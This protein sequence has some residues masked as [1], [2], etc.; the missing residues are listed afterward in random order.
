MANRISP[1]VLGPAG[2]FAIQRELGRGQFG[3]VYL[4]H[5]RDRNRTVALK[6]LERRIVKGLG[7]ERIRQEFELSSS[8]HHDNLAR[9]YELLHDDGDALITMEA[10]E[11][12][13]FVEHVRRERSKEESSRAV[14]EFS[15]CPPEG[16]ARLRATF[17]QLVAA[18]A[19]LHDAGLVHRDLQPAN[20]QVTYDG[21]VV[22]LDYGLAASM[23]VD[24]AGVPQ[25]GLVGAPI[26]VAPEQWNRRAADRASDWY[27]VG[28][29]LFESLTGAPPFRGGAQE[30]ILHKRTVSAPRPSELVSAVPPD[31]DQVAEALLRM[32]P[33]QRPTGKALREQF[34]ITAE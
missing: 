14:P 15:A 26:Y 10:V 31:L 23:L 2:R 9:H 25:D 6:L 4:A 16:I 3:V 34:P 30:V 22:V 18:V 13:D 27:S 24:P 21:R 8:L 1:S 29:V 32:D 12:R 28:V 33:E 7:L 17:P 11:G 20:V 5:D 19:A